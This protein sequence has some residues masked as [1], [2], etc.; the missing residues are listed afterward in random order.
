MNSKKKWISI[1][2]LVA[3]MITIVPLPVL[4]AEGDVPLPAP[5]NLTWH[6]A[7]GWE[8]KY[9]TIGW[10][11]VP[12]A[13]GHYYVEVHRDNELI[14]DTYHGNLYDKDGDGRIYD[15]WSIFELIQESGTYTVSVCADSLT[16]PGYEDSEMVTSE[17]WVYTRPDK[18]LATPTG[19]HWEG[20]TACWDAVPGAA[21]YIIDYRMNGT[22]VVGTVNGVKDW[23]NDGILR[24]D[25]DYLLDIIEENNGEGVYTFTVRAVSSDITE[26]TNSEWSVVSP[27]WVNDGT[28]GGTQ[29]LAAPTGL[30]WNDASMTTGPKT[31]VISWN[32]VPNCEGNYHVTLYN[33]SR[34]VF[35]T[36]W[37][38]LY[39]SDADKVICDSWMTSAN[40]NESGSYTVAVYAEGDGENFTNSE[41][42]V[43]PVW[44]YE[45][46]A[47]QLPVPTGLQWKENKTYWNEVPNAIGYQVKYYKDGEQVGS[48]TGN[49]K[50][51][52]NGLCYDGHDYILKLMDRYGEGIYTFEV[53]ALSGDITAIANGTWSAQSTGNNVTETVEN[54]SDKLDN[55]NSAMNTTTTAE[56]ATQLVQEQVY[57]TAS[58][59][60]AVAMASDDKTE[61]DN[62]VAKVSELEESYKDIMGINVS[63][64]AVE[65][66]Y[67]DASQVTIIGAGLNSTTEKAAVQLKLDKPSKEYTLDELQYKNTVQLSMELANASVNEDGTL[68]VP[69]YITMPVPTNITIPKNF[70]ILHYRQNGDGFDEIHPNFNEDYTMAS[71]ML[72]HFSDFVLAEAT[73]TE[74]L[75]GDVNGDGKITA[76]DMQSIYAHMNGSELLT[77]TALQL[78]DVNEDGSI[79]AADMQNIYAMMNSSN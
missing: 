37:S 71:F 74:G 76:A 26:I 22:D 2:V 58:D 54:I 28:T 14:Y 62:V 51:D 24:H 11:A 4:A 75:L 5:T 55:W 19:L 56:S 46:P 77:G 6:D 52:G 7:P 50:K 17:P 67:T 23:D 42:V 36:S 44:V 63:V 21:V 10:D 3:F 49:M 27:E 39:D 16:L 65:G 13:D 48:I 72:T 70:V 29:Q 79:T 45:K 31:G 18:Q 43:S 68:K 41:E 1:L 40:I 57:G 47:E 9:G 33:G 53:R 32:A 64:T 34:E 12:E 66:S 59:E 78:A 38:G 60:I 61:R 20:T 25:Y 15:T 35:S 30:K 8:L 69:V 73:T